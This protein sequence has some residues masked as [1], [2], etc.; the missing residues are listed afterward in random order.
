MP[1][2]TLSIPNELHNVV[3]K[4]NEINWSEIARRAM[5]IQ[6][7]KLQLM[8]QL[9]E[10]SEFTEKDVEDL[11]KKIKEGLFKRFNK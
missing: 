2:M 4:H 7:K 6:A 9:V 1:N 11:D 10:K 3:K 5:L 8:E